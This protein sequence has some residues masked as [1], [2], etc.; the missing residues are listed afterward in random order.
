MLIKQSNSVPSLGVVRW[1]IYE[2]PDGTELLDNETV[3]TGSL[4]EG[5]V[6]GVWQDSPLPIEHPSTEA[7]N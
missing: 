2:A 5:C 1:R 6:L 4:P 3:F 7:T